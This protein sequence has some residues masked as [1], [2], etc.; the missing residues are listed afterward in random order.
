MAT[1]FEY[2]LAVWD[3]GYDAFCDNDYTTCYDSNPEEDGDLYEAWADG[4]DLLLQETTIT[5]I[6]ETE[7]KK[8][9]S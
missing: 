3:R 1:K 7:Q 9:I 6:C 2:D 8:K 5:E 4:H